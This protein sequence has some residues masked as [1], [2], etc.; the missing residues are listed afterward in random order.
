MAEQNLRGKIDA[1]GNRTDKL[2]ITGPMLMSISQNYSTTYID[3]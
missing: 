3:I 2:K 1:I